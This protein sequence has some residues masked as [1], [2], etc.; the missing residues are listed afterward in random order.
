MISIIKYKTY[1]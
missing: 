1:I